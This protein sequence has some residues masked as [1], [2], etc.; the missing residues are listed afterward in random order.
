MK[1]RTLGV[2]AL[3][4]LPIFFSFVSAEHIRPFTTHFQCSQ[5]EILQ[6]INDANGTVT[7]TMKSGQFDT[8]TRTIKGIFGYTVYIENWGTKEVWYNSTATQRTMFS[9]QYYHTNVSGNVP[10]KLGSYDGNIP[11]LYL[12][13]LM[14]ITVQVTVTNTSTNLTLERSGIEL[15]SSFFIWLTGPESVTGPS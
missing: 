8:K 6:P 15:F 2:A 14:T 13:P 9:H 11:V 3:L 1:T 7:I 12:H 4:L 10:P 5:Y